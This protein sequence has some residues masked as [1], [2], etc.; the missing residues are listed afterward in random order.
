MSKARGQFSCLRG[1]KTVPLLHLVE[2][3]I[4]F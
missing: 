4:Y 3:L 1:M 2:K